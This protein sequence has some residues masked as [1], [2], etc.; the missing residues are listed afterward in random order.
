MH[1]HEVIIFNE[2]IE[3]YMLDAYTFILHDNKCVLVQKFS[4]CF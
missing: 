1:V 2:N 4:K 3:K